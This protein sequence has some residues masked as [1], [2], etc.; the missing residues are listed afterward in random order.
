[1]EK[2]VKV[3]KECGADEY[4]IADMIHAY[5]TEYGKQKMIN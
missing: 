2:L 3:L 4:D 5:L 1:M